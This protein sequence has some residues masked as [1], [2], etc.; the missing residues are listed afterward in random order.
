MKQEVNWW[1]ILYLFACIGGAGLISFTDIPNYWSYIIGC[2]V[3]GMIYVIKQ[4]EIT[5]LEDNNGK[6]E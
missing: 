1:S 6:E 5:D 3:Y 4:V 2:L